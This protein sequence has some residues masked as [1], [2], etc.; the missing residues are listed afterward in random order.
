MPLYLWDEPIQSK[1]RKVR[2]A[3]RVGASTR[4]R[5][6]KT[7]RI[8]GAQ[9]FRERAVTSLHVHIAYPHGFI[10]ERCRLAVI[11]W[12][13]RS[14]VNIF[15]AGVRLLWCRVSRVVQVSWWFISPL[16]SAAGTHTRHRQRD[17]F[18]CS[19]INASARPFALIINRTLVL[20]YSRHEI[21]QFHS[22]GFGSDFS[23]WWA[24]K[25]Q[26]FL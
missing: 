24:I 6:Q 23:A 4:W 8:I 7:N 12:A 18:N 26:P 22:T 15:G 20:L 17:N 2:I 11:Q 1:Y 25:K 9:W 21:H 5:R 19:G 13:G 10:C 14:L 16:V 3:A